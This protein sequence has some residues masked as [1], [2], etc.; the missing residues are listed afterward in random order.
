M[1]Q[2][3]VVHGHATGKRQGGDRMEG[4]LLVN[5]Q[6]ERMKRA[7][8]P[9]M[10]VPKTDTRCDTGE[11]APLRKGLQAKQKSMPRNK[12][13]RKT[14]QRPVSACPFHTARINPLLRCSSMVL[15]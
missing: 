13:H 4:M 5:G 2:S 3:L 15:L 11:A 14:R 8:A 7:Q 9:R 6:P 1:I 10:I 12:Q